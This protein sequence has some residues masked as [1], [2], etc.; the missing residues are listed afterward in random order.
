MSYRDEIQKKVDLGIASTVAIWKMVTS[1]S[2]EYQTSLG[3]NQAGVKELERQKSHISMYPSIEDELASA[4]LNIEID[5]EQFGLVVKYVCG[6]E[7]GDT[8]RECLMVGCKSN[9][10]LNLSVGYG[11]TL[12]FAVSKDWHKRIISHLTEAET[13]PPPWFPK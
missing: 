10:S 11:T 2:D 9:P 4:I 13:P 1:H 3:L 5:G 12:V 8:W 7:Y 6:C